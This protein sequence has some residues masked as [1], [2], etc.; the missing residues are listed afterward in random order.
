MSQFYT[1]VL[2]YIEHYQPKRFER[3]KRERRLAEVVD[4]LVGELYEESDRAYA[5][6]S[7][8]HADISEAQRRLT[9]ERIAIATVLPMPQG[10]EFD[11]T[12]NI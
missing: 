5:Q 6:L 1:T 10:D 7:G 11:A 9:A 12:N 8:Y 3:L 4:G 2:N